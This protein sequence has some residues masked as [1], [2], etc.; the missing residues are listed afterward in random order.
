MG[1]GTA[2]DRPRARGRPFHQNVMKAAKKDSCKVP[3][4]CLNQ[5]ALAGGV[6]TITVGPNASFGTRL[7][8]A[9]D[10]WAHFRVLSL[11]FRLHPVTSAA[12]VGDQAAGFV[13]GVQDSPPGSIAAVMELLPSI[14]LSGSEAAGQMSTTTPTTW[15]SVSRQDLAGPLP[16]YKTI[17]GTADATEEAP[18]VLSVVGT[19]TNTFNLEIRGVFEFKT[20][21]STANTPAEVT[22]RRLIREERRLDIAN[23]AKLR[24]LGLLGSPLPSPGSPGSDSTSSSTRK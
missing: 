11:R 13:G 5:S 6:G 22:L 24:M 7:L 23:R 21:V 9:G 8:A 12:A 19:G 16:W 1:G 17:P 3:F 4:H 10:E 18:G 2:S 20:A 15:V 14:F